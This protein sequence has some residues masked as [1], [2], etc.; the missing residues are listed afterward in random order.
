[1]HSGSLQ[2]RGQQTTVKIESQYTSPNPTD[3]TVSLCSLLEAVLQRFL[4]HRLYRS[5]NQ[6]SAGFMA[7]QFVL[8]QLYK[9]GNK[10]KQEA[11][12]KYCTYT[13][14]K[15]LLVQRIFFFYK[16]K[17]LLQ[18][19][20]RTADKT[21]N[22]IRQFKQADRYNRKKARNHCAVIVQYYITL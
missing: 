17:N 19:A 18:R 20:N 11:G 12:S 21:Q 14:G 2:N 1:M 7:V 15:A 5:S 16:T 10:A 6:T 4:R 13:T 3:N 8:L 22:K 9:W